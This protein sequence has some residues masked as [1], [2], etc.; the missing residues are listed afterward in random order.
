[1]SLHAGMLG[2]S[3]KSL[4][5]YL[6]LSLLE[7]WVLAYP[8]IRTE[9]GNDVPFACTDPCSVRLSLYL[10]QKVTDISLR[11]RTH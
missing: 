6:L 8:T 4:P 3:K 10:G 2:M 11:K 5:A 7:Y 9:T 1:M